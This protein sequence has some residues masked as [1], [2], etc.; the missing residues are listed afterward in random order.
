MVFQFKNKRGTIAW[1]YVAAIIIAIV[2][3][4][5]IIVFSTSLRDKIISSI[6]NFGKWG[7][8]R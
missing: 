3:L 1:E 4:I 2:V 5:I 7:F 6:T 8:G